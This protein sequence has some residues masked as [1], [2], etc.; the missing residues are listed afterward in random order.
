MFFN[1]LDWFGE[2]VKTK[3]ASVKEAR[4]LQAGTRLSAPRVREDLGR[5]LYKERKGRAQDSG[6]VQLH[7]GLLAA[8]CSV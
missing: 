2:R 6:L 3:P 8:L 1:L 4:R 5:E 7:H